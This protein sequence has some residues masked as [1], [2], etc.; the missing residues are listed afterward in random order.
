MTAAGNVLAEIVESKQALLQAAMQ[1]TPLAQIQRAAA[2]APAPRPFAAALQDGARLPV[3]A[4]IKRRSPSKGVLCEPFAPAEIAAAYAEGGAACLSVLTDEEFFG[5]CDADLAAARQASGLPV[6][7]KDFM[8]HEWQIFAS[9]AIGADAILLIAAILEDDVLHHLAEVAHGLG[10][11]VLVE[12]HDAAEAARARRL[13]GDI[14]LGINNRDLKTFATTI[15][16][17]LDLLP[18][19]KGDARPV[20]SESGLHSPEDI[21]RLRQAGVSAFLIG[22]ALMRD[23]QRG[24][25]RLFEQEQPAVADE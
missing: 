10:M 6:L 19:L 24:L 9:R 14:L 2:A 25:R 7:R 17:T 22:E 23:P 18:L 21:R 16:T 15:Q 20:V 8:L 5:G 4:E 3:I 12:V 11:A 13:P 1:Q